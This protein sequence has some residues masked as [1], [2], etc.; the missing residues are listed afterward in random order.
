MITSL[1]TQSWGPIL[2]D[3]NA[4]FV[5]VPSGDIYVVSNIRPSTGD[6]VVLKSNAVPPDP[7]PGNSFSSI[8][9]VSLNGSTTNF[10]P[11]AV[12]DATSSLPLLHIIGLVTN[13]NPKLTDLVKFTINLASYQ[14]TGPITLISGSNLQS[15]YDICVLTGEG[16]NHKLVAVSANNPVSPALFQSPINS[17]SIAN[18]VLTVTTSNSFYIGQLVELNGL[19]NAP[20]LNG[21]KAEVTTSSSNQFTALFY[22]QDIEEA[23]IVSN[24]SYEVTA[25]DLTQWESDIKVMDPE[26]GFILTKVGENPSTY[27]YTVSSGVYQFNSYYANKPVLISYNKFFTNS[28]DVGTAT[29]LFSGESL[30]SFRLDSADNLVNNSL[31]VII[32]TPTRD[33]DTI[34]S[35]SIIS[36][37]STNAEVYYQSHPK[38]ISPNSQMLFS[39]YRINLNQIGSSYVWDTSPTLLTQ[40]KGDYTGNR[41]TAQIDGLGNRYLNQTYYTSSTHPEGL[42]GNII[43]GKSNSST[44]NTWEFHITYGSNINGSIVQGTL[45]LSYTQG[46]TLVYLLEP[47]DTANSTSHPASYPLHIGSISN[48][49]VFTDI[50]AYNGQYLTWLRGS[51]SIID[52]V[53]LWT[54]IGERRNLSPSSELHLV[55]ANYPYTTTV[56]HASSY[57]QNASVVDYSGTNPVILSSVVS[58]PSINQYVA[59]TNGVYSF[60]KEYASIS[61]TGISLI[62]G[63][64]TVTGTNISNLSLGMNVVFSNLTYATY[65]NNEVVTVVYIDTTNSTFVSNFSHGDD[66]EHA[67]NG[68]VGR[69]ISF[70][71]EYISSVSPVY[72]S[73]FNVPPIASLTSES[74]TVYRN[75][76][77]LLDATGSVDKD[78]D[79]MEFIWSN[80]SPNVSNISITPTEASGI[81]KLEVGAEIGGGAQSFNIGVA[82]IDTYSDGTPRHNAYPV[83]NIQI[84]NAGIVSATSNIPLATRENLMLYGIALTPPSSVTFGYITGLVASVSS[85]NITG[86]ILTADTTSEVFGV[87]QVIEFLG[88]SNFTFLNGTTSI[89]N[90]VGYTTP[91]TYFRTNYPHSNTVGTDTGT[92]VY[93]P[94]YTYYVKLTYVNPVGESA[95][96]AEYSYTPGAGNLLIVNSPPALGNAQY[97]NV[98]MSTASENEQLQNSSPI[99]LGTNFTLPVTGTSSGR[100]SPTASTAFI[101]SLNDKILTTVSSSGTSFTASTLGVLS[102]LPSTTVV[103]Y[104]IPQ[105]QFSNMTI[106][107]PYNAPPTIVFPSSTWGNSTPQINVGRN[108]E[109]TIGESAPYPITFTGMSDI[110]DYP[111]YTWQ[112]TSGTPVYILGETSSTLTIQTNGANINGETLGFNLVINDGVNPSVSSSFNVVVASYDFTSMDTK[113]I[114]RSLWSGTISQRNSSQTWGTQD[115]S[116]IYSNFINAKVFPVEGSNSRYLVVSNYSVFVYGLENSDQLVIRKILPLNGSLIVDAVIT[117][118][119]YAL[120]IDSNHRL[121]RYSPVSTLNT[122]NP[123]TI[124]D[125]S[126]FTSMIFTGLLST[127]SHANERVI[128]LYG[129]NGCLLLQVANDTLEVTGSYELTISSNL[130]FGS[131]DVQFIRLVNVESVNHGQVLIGTKAT[132]NGV[133]TTYES[134]I[135]LNQNKVLGVWDAF[136]LKNQFVTTGEILF[137]PISPYSGYPIAPVQNVP[138][139]SY[140]STIPQVTISWEQERPDLMS[141]YNVEYAVQ[142]ICNTVVDSSLQYNNTPNFNADLGVVDNYSTATITQ[143]G[144]AS[145]VLT[146]TCSNDFVPGKE[147]FLS[148]LYYATFLNG[149]TVTILAATSTYFTANFTH[150]NYSVTSDFGLAKELLNQILTY[151]SSTPGINQYSVSPSGVYMF[152]SSQ[153]NHSLTISY[154][155]NFNLLHTVNSGIIETLSIPIPYGTYIFRLKALSLDGNSGY[156]NTQTISI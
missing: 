127:N 42:V 7:G 21:Y 73:D 110:D 36:P 104:A 68:L 24:S 45:C 56:S 20:F 46:L 99:P 35:V 84:D 101:V 90:A 133:I 107:V 22:Y 79:S 124:I 23:H 121:L 37:D 98:Y 150:S 30:I 136:N 91:P 142:S 135:N 80:N 19:S 32:N 52:D 10:D 2:R 92:A 85:L 76:P 69:P 59:G 137:D 12:Y 55:S 31:E 123:D 108:V 39:F 11:V 116:T 81:S 117:E 87:G 82:V 41:L 144:V 97:Y 153:E 1:D 129:P 89:I 112:Q 54:I 57:W 49:M 53:S 134:L 38:L 119:D 48:S 95:A 122:D 93:P 58:N 33:G 25:T 16:A 60:N 4:Q 75:S 125:L 62:G 51:K 143:V 77:M 70:N 88:F 50:G 147:V 131:N 43:L 140:A 86:N 146:V 78:N 14:V 94:N 64:L 96:S 74:T 71:Y 118:D 63:V 34:D 114:S 139:V 83:T 151:T 47:F 29:P 17:V 66:P 44:G 105:Y 102:S 13:T 103:G 141:S 154:R 148:G 3:G 18:S 149:I 27:E 132:V 120:V 109:I 130:I 100:Y 65:L 156:S 152:N 5:K 111:T 115:T 61:I 40:F 8:A 155:S 126:D 67:D 26:T 138:V 28:S 6:F 145:N 128:A 15:T 113:Q 72:I 106:N 9:T